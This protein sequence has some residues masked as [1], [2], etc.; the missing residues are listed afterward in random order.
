MSIQA[1]Y[2]YGVG[3]GP[4]VCRRYGCCGKRNIKRVISGAVSMQAVYKYG[5]GREP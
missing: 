1:A 4:C 3:R 2:K 5:V